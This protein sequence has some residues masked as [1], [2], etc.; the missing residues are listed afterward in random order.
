MHSLACDKT[1]ARTHTHTCACT[2]TGC[3]WRCLSSPTS[4]S[5]PPYPPLPPSLPRACSHPPS[6]SFHSHIMYF[7]R[8]HLGASSAASFNQLFGGQPDH[9]WAYRYPAH[10]FCGC[11]HNP[12]SLTHAMRPGWD[13]GGDGGASDERAHKHTC[14]FGLNARGRSSHSTLSK[15]V[16]HH[17]IRTQCQL[18][19]RNSVVGPRALQASSSF[20]ILTQTI[21][22]AF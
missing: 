12:S 15:D 3:L 13:A 10:D 11:T 9:D 21:S 6:P 22:T 20:C 8:A 19:L 1:N 4:I 5:L 16:Y 2:Y 14:V 17:L 18:L 7:N